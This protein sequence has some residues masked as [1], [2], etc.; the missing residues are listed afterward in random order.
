MATRILPL[1]LGL[2]ALPSAQVL[3]AQ[4]D[5]FQM[6]GQRTTA[7]RGG[8]TALSFDAS[9]RLWFGTP[10]GLF[11]LDPQPVLQS[12]EPVTHFALSRDGAVRLLRRTPIAITAAGGL[13][14]SP[15]PDQTVLLLDPHAGANQKTLKLATK[16]PVQWLAFRPDGARLHVL[17]SDRFWIE[18]DT[19]SGRILRK[20][21]EPDSAIHS[22]ALNSAGTLLALGTAFTAMAKGSVMRDAHP[23]HFHRESRIRIYDVAQGQLVKQIDTLPGEPIAMAFS[24]DSRFLAVI[25]RRVR[26]S[27]LAVYDAQ[28]GTEIASAP[29]SETTAAVA[30]DEEG[31]HLAW[32]APNDQMAVAEIRGVF[33]GVESGD[34]AGVRVRMTSRDNTPLIAPASPTV[35]AILNLDP[36]GVPA[37]IALTLS[38]MLRNRI[39]GT[40]N[41]ALVERERMERLLKEQDFQLTERASAVDAIRLG[42]IL[43]AKKAVFGSVSQ[44]GAS[45]LISVSL[46]DVETARTDGIREVLCQRCTVDD[47]ADVVAILTPALVAR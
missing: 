4:S 43:N 28:R 6:S 12:S 47:L 1:M 16:K 24:P 39:S 37:P 31:K 21:E 34:L 30:F 3:R 32:S 33:R 23:S 15:G 41:I 5:L 2:W 40:Q 17:T 35:I 10:H 36:I 45:Y 29:A 19:A 18:F 26:A 11:R 7:A 27:M 13:A 22:A 44:L 25:R 20:T 14:A 9:G 46:V 8:V 38:E 42:R